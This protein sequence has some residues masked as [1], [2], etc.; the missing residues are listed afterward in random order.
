M[1][2]NI[3]YSNM[4]ISAKG[5]AI[6][7]PESAPMSR[8]KDD[9]KERNML[10]ATQGFII[11]TDSNHMILSAVQVQTPEQRLFGGDAA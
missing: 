3:G 5:R 8:P 9:A 10:G 11:V 4:V 1:P 6:L 7:A 2:V